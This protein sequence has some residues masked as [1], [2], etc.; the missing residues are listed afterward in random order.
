[1]LVYRRLYAGNTE[2]FF[3]CLE[4]ESKVAERNI[5]VVTTA[6]IMHFKLEKK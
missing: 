6:N 4:L 1:M 5:L 3:I 2:Y